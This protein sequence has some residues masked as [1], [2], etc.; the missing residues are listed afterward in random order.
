MKLDGTLPLIIH[1]SCPEIVL[2]RLNRDELDSDDR[3]SCEQRGQAKFGPEP[4]WV[5][6]FLTRE[7]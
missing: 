1:I 5:F 3:E 4:A 7:N 6:Q 2:E